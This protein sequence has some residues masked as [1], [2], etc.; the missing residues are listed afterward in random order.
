MSTRKSMT[1]PVIITLIMIVI[2]IYLFATIKQ[3]QVVCE[4]VRTF[5][6]DVRLEEK[7]VSTLDGKSIK[8]ISIVKIITL[9][10]KYAK[11]TYLNSIKFSLESTLNYLGDKV[12]Y[13][14]DGN[15][16]IVKINVNKDE[17]V[18]LDN[19]D[20]IDNGDLEI[21]VNSNTKSSEV[22]T[23][24]VGDNYT[25]GELMKRLKNNG[26]ICK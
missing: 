20:F 21:K 6:S 7:I 12:K 15:K 25:D 26:Y 13:T 16:L 22:V 5:D 9:P 1:L 8:E 17:V 23:L 10:D 24:T 2:I 3:S 11:E 18:L 19:I 14:T 4:K